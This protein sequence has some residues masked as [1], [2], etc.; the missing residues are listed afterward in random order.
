M[1][2]VLN[3][4]QNFK[5]IKFW[6]MLKTAKRST[7]VTFS[8]MYSMPRSQTFPGALPLSTH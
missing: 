2:S 5:K 8:E 7:K 6:E 4:N 3:L 1:H